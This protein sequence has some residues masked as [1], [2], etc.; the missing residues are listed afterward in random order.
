MAIGNTVRVVADRRTHVVRSTIAVTL[1]LF[2]VVLAG[3]AVW[4]PVARSRNVAFYVAGQSVTEAHVAAMTTD[5]PFDPTS[6][7]YQARVELLSPTD[8]KAQYLTAG[9][10]TEA[11]QRLVIMHVQEAEAAKLGITV[12]PFDVDAAVQAYVKDHAMQGDTAEVQ[13]LRSPEMRSYIELRAVSQAYENNLTKATTVS[14]NDIS[15][16]YATWGWNYKDAQGKQLTFA[17][18]R[19]RLAKDALANKK[20]QLVLENRS[21]MLKQAS[22][23]VH[24]DTRYK[25][26]MRWWDIMFGIQVPDTL[27]ALQVDTAS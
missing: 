26:F 12:S 19:E 11:I 22:A 1:A 21:Q 4:M 5:L 20:F 6:D 8:P 23:L 18:A 15:Q 7:H 2:L 10:K 24:G 13:R 17:Q 9:L 14:A 16:Y 27:Q 3:L 25:K